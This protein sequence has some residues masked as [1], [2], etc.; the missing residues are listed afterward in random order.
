MA[1]GHIR[2]SGPGAW[3]LKYDVGVNPT[4]GQRITKFKTVRGAKRDAQRELR[5]ILTALDGGTY[6]DPSKM[7]VRQWLQQWLDEAQH[8]VARKTLQRY[9]EIVD[10]HLIPALGAI[11]LAKLQPVQIQAYYSQALAAGVG[12]AAAAFQRRRWCTMTACSTWHR[13][14]RGRSA[15]SPCNPEEDVSRQDRTPRDRGPGAGR[16]RGLPVAAHG[17]ACSRSLPD[18]RHRIVAR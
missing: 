9:R 15:S 14:G 2:A 16:E 7:T 10:L 4:T 8:G 18:T 1:K 13:S 17:P 3:E 12:M 6:A 11:P 5:A